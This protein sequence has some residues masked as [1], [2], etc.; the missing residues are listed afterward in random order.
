LQGA[1]ATP[2]DP[3]QALSQNTTAS[4]A[5]GNYISGVVNITKRFT[6]H[7]Q[8]FA[9]YIW[10]QNKDN[11][12]SERDT[13]TYFGQQD[14][15]NL[16]LD[17]G[18]NGLDIKHQFK[19]A[20][21]YEMPRGFALSSS[22]IAHSGVPFP[23]YINVDVNADQVSDNGHNNDRPLYTTSGGKT[24]LL[25]RYPFNQPGYV[26]QEMRILKDF[27]A[28]DRYHVQLQGDF[29]N[30][31]NHA[32][33]YSNPDISGTVDYS[34]NCTP[35]AAPAAPVGGDGTV[36]GPIGYSCTPFTAATLPRP[37]TTTSAGTYRAINQIAPGSTPFSFQAGIKFIF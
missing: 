15:F 9:N 22:V 26:E 31:W 21:V 2:F 19:A 28:H 12:A 27:N 29:F 1:S 13:D 4:F 10:S 25:G 36:T 17:Y 24:V 34:G 18:R 5:R 11:G 32:N 37:G 6:N 35:Y 16:N 33:K 14:P 30:V 3:S 8:V 7:F 20:G 23:L